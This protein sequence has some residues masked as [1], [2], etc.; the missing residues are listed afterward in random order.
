MNAEWVFA[1]GSNM[2]L[3]DLRAWL[4][5]HGYDADGILKATRARLD[6]YALVWNYYSHT[7][8]GGAANIEPRKG[9]TV[10]GVA[11]RVTT[12]ALEGIDAKEGHPKYYT[13]GG[14]EKDKVRTCLLPAETPVDCWLYRALR[15]RCSDENE[16]PTRC[17]LRLV[18]EAAQKRGLPDEY[19][20][21]L[22]ATPVCDE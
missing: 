7:R 11:L 21:K 14:S 10:Y 20:E 19:V 12:G 9:E 16:W 8:C 15:E 22:R 6:G 3:C 5:N 18:I 17:Y 2:N 4:A 1:Y 13:R